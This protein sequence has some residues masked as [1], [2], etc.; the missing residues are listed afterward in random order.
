MKA[1]KLF[2]ILCLFGICS[3]HTDDVKNTYT[4]SGKVDSFFIVNFLPNN[5]IEIDTLQFAVNLITD[6]QI[7]ATSDDT[8]FTFT[9]LE[10][11]KSYYVIPEQ[12][13]TNGIGMTALDLV[14][15]R[16]YIEGG[17]V[18]DA[19]QKLAADVNKNSL[20]DSTDLELIEN[21]LLNTE[22]CFNWRF[23][24]DD[25]DGSGI[26]QADQYIIDNLMSDVTIHFIPIKTGDI[27]GTHIPH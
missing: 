15:V 5:E 20:I 4:I 18:L 23:A 6:D 3:C 27:T 11:G 8:V 1:E 25:Y 10:E 13:G 9:G 19:F 17:Q 12:L 21:C 26:G 2:V 24:T 16:K 7:I 22:Q 14:M